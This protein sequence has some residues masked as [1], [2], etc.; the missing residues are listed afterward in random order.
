MDNLFAERRARG[1]PEKLIFHTETPK[2]GGFFTYHE[3]FDYPEKGW[4][5][6]YA[7]QANNL[8]KMFLISWGRFLGNKSLIPLYLAFAI[9]PW[10]VKSKIIERFIQEV[11]NMA[12][13]CFQ[14]YQ[15]KYYLDSQYYTI[16]CLELGKFVTYFLRNLGFHNVAENLGF[17]VATLIEYDTAYRYRL[18]DL[19]SET[20]AEKMIEIPRREINKLIRLYVQREKHKDL[21]EKFISIGRILSW[22]LLIPRVKKTFKRTIKQIEFKNLQLDEIDYYHVRNQIGYDFFGMTIQERDKK[23]PREGH[24][25]LDIDYSLVDDKILYKTFI[26]NGV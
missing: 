12:N 11:C 19:F 2:S 3:S 20:S 14:T 24:T 6:E 4:R 7:V 26:N 17:V 9:T 23:W 18:E 16:S 8:A 22:A 5:N 21:P 1:K 15:H 25:I 13:K 10:R